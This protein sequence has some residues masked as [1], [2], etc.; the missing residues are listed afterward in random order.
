MDSATHIPSLGQ[1]TAQ[2]FADV[3]SYQV[4][5][6]LNE[7]PAAQLVTPE[8]LP[9]P[10][11][12]L[13]PELLDPDPDPL[14][15]SVPP[16][17]D[18]LLDPDPASATPELTP[19]PEPDPDPAPDPDEL[20]GIPLPDPEEDPVLPLPDPEPLVATLGPEDEPDVPRLPSPPPS[21][22]P[23]VPV[24]SLHAKGIDAKNAIATDMYS[25][26]R[27]IYKAPRA[28]RK[29]RRSP[30]V[31]RLAAN[32]SE[33][34]R[35]VTDTR[36]HFSE[37][38]SGVRAS[39]AAPVA[40]LPVLDSPRVRRGISTLDLNISAAVFSSLDFERVCRRASSLD[41]NMS[42][43]VLHRSI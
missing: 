22:P 43:A 9:D 5:P 21:S 1:G 18:P 27:I 28:S 26:G 35:V 16:E 41:S 38:Q 31:G 13:D 8:E 4:N 7:A 20:P 29:F 14:S 30:I 24:E 39:I 12:Q 2:L 17:L 10:D 34:T 3:W 40:W 36:V 33:K 23:T 32:G 42:A 11:P 37:P 6:A 19:D 25:E 15:G